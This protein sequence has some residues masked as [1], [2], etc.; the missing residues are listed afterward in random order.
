MKQTNKQYCMPDWKLTYP[1]S[2]L[3]D[4]VFAHH[5]GVVSV[6]HHPRCDVTRPVVNA[7]VICPPCKTTG[8]EHTGRLLMMLS[9]YVLPVCFMIVCLFVCFTVLFSACILT[10]VEPVLGCVITPFWCRLP[11]S[12]HRL[13]MRRREI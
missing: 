12:G 8:T 6:Q 4:P 2:Q 7:E 11:F 9:T 3:E 13:Y 10:F 1:N 5:G